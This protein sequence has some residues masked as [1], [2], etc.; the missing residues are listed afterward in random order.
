MEWTAGHSATYLMPGDNVLGRDFRNSRICCCV[1]WMM[2]K[3]SRRASWNV[4]DPFIA[5][6][7]K[8]ATSW[9][10][11]Q[12]CANSSMPSSRITVES[13]SKHTICEFRITWAAP[14]AFFDL[15]PSNI[16]NENE[17]LEW[18][19]SNGITRNGEVWI[20]GGVAQRVSVL[21]GEFGEYLLDDESVGVMFTRF[22]PFAL[23]TGFTIV[24]VFVRCAP[25][26]NMLAA[27][28]VGFAEIATNPINE[29]FKLERGWNRITWCFIS[30]SKIG[31]CLFVCLCHNSK[32]SI[33]FRHDAQ[34]GF[35]VPEIFIEEK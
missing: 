11:P 34:N 16:E 1:G 4:I 9:P 12:N 29:L 31:L 10:L 28:S 25:L 23:W 20:F 8:R 21:C 35:S 2:F 27:F 3:R 22:V 17:T 26:D 14:A 7:V 19:A 6:F 33:K 5:S 24:G 15:S 18:R 30:S 13:T 32:T